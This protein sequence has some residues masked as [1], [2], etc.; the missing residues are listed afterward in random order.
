MTSKTTDGAQSP[1][2]INAIAVESAWMLRHDLIDRPASDR[3]VRIKGIEP[4]MTV[5][6]R[7]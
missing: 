1:R 3:S 5:L 7:S 4:G 6:S 2:K